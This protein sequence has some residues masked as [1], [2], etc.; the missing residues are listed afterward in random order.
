MSA[1]ATVTYLDQGRITRVLC[2]D[3][4]PTYGM[5]RDGYTKRSGAP[6]GYMI[7][8][9]G[10]ARWRRVMV[11]QFSNAGTCFVRINGKPQVIDDMGYLWRLAECRA[12]IEY[13]TGACQGTMCGK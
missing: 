4:P 11:W 8:L 12:C 9:D 1:T 13:G 7:Q 6:T 2:D 3:K 5:C 10:E